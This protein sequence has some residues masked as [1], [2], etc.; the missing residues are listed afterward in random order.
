MGAP[1]IYDISRLRVNF[2]IFFWSSEY[3]THRHTQK[4]WKIISIEK[5]TN[6]KEKDA[7]SKSNQYLK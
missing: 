6:S 2:R 7:F 5:S 3:F 1:Y 4:K